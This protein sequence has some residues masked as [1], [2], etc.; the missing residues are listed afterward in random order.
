MEKDNVIERDYSENNK[1]F[2]SY[3][4]SSP[5]EAMPE[6]RRLLF[7]AYTCDYSLISSEGDANGPGI[8]WTPR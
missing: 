7:N 3:S 5:K 2:L 6:M 4:L 1:A 8:I